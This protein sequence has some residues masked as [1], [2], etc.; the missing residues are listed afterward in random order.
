MKGMAILNSCEDEARKVLIKKVLDL[1]AKLNQWRREYYNL[2]A[3]TV[4]DAVYDRHFDELRH[5]ENEAGFQH[6]QFP[7]ADSWIRSSR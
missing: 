1:T 7:H 2:N 6:E 4:T 3:P 5:L